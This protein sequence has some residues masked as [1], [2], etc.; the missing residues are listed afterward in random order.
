MHTHVHK[1]RDSRVDNRTKIPV[2]IRMIKC[3]E[4]FF[5]F[6]VLLYEIAL[7]WLYK[8]QR[9]GGLV[10]FGILPEEGVFVE[11]MLDKMNYEF[12]KQQL[13]KLKLW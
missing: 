1:Q 3:L 7:S 12:F 13:Q 5:F 10:W 4:V 9:R 11:Q 8:F 6:A 2:M